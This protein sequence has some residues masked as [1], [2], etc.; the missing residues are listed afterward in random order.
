MAKTFLFINLLCTTHHPLKKVIP[1]FPAN[2]PLRS[3]QAPLFENLVRGS[4]SFLAERGVFHT[5]EVLD[6]S[7]P[8]HRGRFCLEWQGL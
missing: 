8:L 6:T 4:T 1:S 5:M 7:L 2:S 3:F